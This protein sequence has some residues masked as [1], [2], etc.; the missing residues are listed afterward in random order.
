MKKYLDLL[1]YKGKDKITGFEGILTSISFE[2]YGCVQI[3]I[4]AGLDKEG[5][6]RDSCWFD[7]KRIEKTSDTRILEAPAFDFSAGEEK[8]GD[9]LPIPHSTQR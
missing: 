6:F 3:L 1:G 4:N 2:L 5:K 9:N 8:G 7:A